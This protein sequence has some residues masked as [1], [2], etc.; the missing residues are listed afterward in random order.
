MRLAA[1]VAALA[2]AATTGILG[3][4]QSATAADYPTWDEVSAAR[5]DV[6]QAE[7][8]VRQIESLLA[9]LQAEAERTRVESE[10]KGLI[11]QQAEEKFQAA[12]A[13]ADTLQQQADAAS[14][15]AAASEQRAGQM[16]AQ[17]ARSTGEDF[18]ASLFV[19]GDPDNLLNGIGMSRKITEQSQAIYERAIL[20][21]NTAQA[22]TDQ[23]EVAKAELE[24]LKDAAAKAFAEAQAAAIAAQTALEDQL[25]RQAELQAQLV[26][27]REKRVATEA[28]Y[29]AGVRERYAAAGLD[30]GPISDSGW[31]RP[32]AGYITSSYGWRTDPYYSFH[33]G[34]DIGAGC[35]AP[36]FAAHPGTVIYAGW[37]G[38]YGNFVMI[39]HGGGLTTSYGHIVNGGILVQYGQQVGVAEQ[40]AKVGTTGKSTGCHLHLEVKVNGQTQNPVTFFANQGVRIG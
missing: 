29:L 39:D 25:N 12:A 32:A 9:G 33:T 17:L 14:A 30:A 23:A 15:T 19:S 27:L 34:T 2:L 22:L 40:I 26:V 20:D 28:D 4:T 11:A 10:A 31:V 35:N 5:N 8:L 18:S 1:V 16:A 38:N 24:V 6:A 37:Y 7:A 13:R 21:R 3:A 36:I